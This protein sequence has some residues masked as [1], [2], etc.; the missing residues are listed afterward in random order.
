MQENTEMR[1]PRRNGSI[2]PSAKIRAYIYTLMVAASPLVVYY[3]LATLE[4]VGLWIVFGG[5]A[6]GVSNGVAL[7]NVTGRK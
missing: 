4:E 7:A 3:G 5:V 1:R 6:L 2:I